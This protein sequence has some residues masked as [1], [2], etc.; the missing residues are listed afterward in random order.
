MSELF[1]TNSPDTHHGTQ[2]S[3]FVAFCNVRVHLGPFCYC[4]KLD[5]IGPIWRKLMRKF[6][7]RSRV[8]IFHNECTRSTPLDPKLMF[9]CVLY[10]L[11]SFG[12]ILLPYQ[13]RCK[14]GGNGAIDA[15]VR[16]TKSCWN[17][18]QRTLPIHPIGTWTHVFVLFVLFG[19]FWDCFVAHWNSMQNRAEMVQL[20]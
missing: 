9:S 1:A 6:V 7:P 13:T 15:K 11:G 5:A 14:T 4:T 18:S 16:A 12:T 17:F 2:N 19:C 10:S 3:C 20:M 8:R